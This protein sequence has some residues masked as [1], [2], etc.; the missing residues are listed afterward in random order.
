MIVI[1]ETALVKRKYPC[2]GPVARET[3]WVLGIYDVDKKKREL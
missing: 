3:W 2:G 1:D